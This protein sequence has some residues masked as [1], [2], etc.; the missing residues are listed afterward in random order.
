MQTTNGLFVGP[1]NG[2]LSWALANEKVRAVHA[3]EN[4]AYFLKPVSRTFHGRDVFAPVAAH[5]SSGVPITKFGPV[6]K[7][8]VRLDWPEPRRQR[9]G[10]KGEVLYIDRFGNAITNL[11]SSLLRGSDLAACEV[12]ARRR[13]VCPLRPFYQ[14]VA[15]KTP[16]ALAGSSGFLEIAINGGSAEEALGVRIGTPVVLR[17]GTPTPAG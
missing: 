17:M 5:L 16:V 6:L 15:P 4:E 8:F 10:I 9:G 3:L 12:S 7:D 2:V 14:A 13:W 11:E 1:D